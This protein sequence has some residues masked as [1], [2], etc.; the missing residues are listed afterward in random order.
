MGSKPIFNCFLNLGLLYLVKAS[1]AGNSKMKKASFLILIQCISL[2][3]KGQSSDPNNNHSGPDFRRT[4]TYMVKENKPNTPI[5]NYSALGKKITVYTTAK[6]TPLNLSKENVVDFKYFPQPFETQVCIFIEPDIRFQSILGIGGALTDAVAE[7]MDK[8]P[9]SAQQEVLTAYYDREKGIA[10]NLA[11]TNINSCD[12]SS[13]TYT[14]VSDS[15]KD[16]RTFN[17]AHDEKFKIPLI[18]KA[19][20][21]AGGNLTLFVSPWSPP[22]WMKDNNSMLR[23]GHLKEE[24][25]QS[26]A[27]YYVKFIKA[28]EKK[29]IPIWGLSVQNEP[30]A[31]QSWESCV[32]SAEE[33]RDFVKTYLGPTL[34][35][36]GLKE[37]K[38]IVWDHN[39]DLIFQ[40]ANTIYSDPEASKYIWGAGFHWYETWTGSKMEFNNVKSVSEAYPDKNLMFTEGC[41]ERFD[42]SKL[43]E[44]ALGER[45]GNSI[46]NDF[47]SGAVAWTDWNILLDQT[48]GPNHV[49]NFCYAPIIGDT[50]TGKLI[51]TN[52]YPYLG[53]FSKFIRPGAKRIASSSNRDIL[54][55]TAFMNPDGSVVVI[56]LNTSDK[57]QAYQLAIKNQAAQGTSLPHSISTLVVEP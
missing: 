42:F 1:F 56:V 50:R 40:R 53:H 57:E 47:N 41:I 9:K 35:N 30:M 51:Y 16:L 49:G 19:I 46:L 23:G 3:I 39:R 5:S 20:E 10:Y 27:N 28:Y 7:T 33:E 25:K 26:W 36:N 13:D 4:Q 32:Y 17:L 48:G 8:L 15:S 37:K 45:Y 6:N 12:F 14:Y 21:A 38:L 2:L 44:W 52:I 31:K 22:A 18:K 24:Y 29:G 54:Q 55:T 43:N 11:R 34:V